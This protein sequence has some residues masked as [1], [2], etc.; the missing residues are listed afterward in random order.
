MIRKYSFALYVALAVMVLPAQAAKAPKGV[1]AKT[2]ADNEAVRLHQKISWLALLGNIGPMCGLLGTVWGMIQAFSSIALDPAQVK[3][4]TMAYSVSKAMI[5]TAAGLML[6]IPA[7][8]AYYYLR[9][10]VI[11]IVAEVEAH[12]SELVELLTREQE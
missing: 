2:A 5:T 6:A 4:M 11:K 8:L 3:G 9:G 12:S 10:R 7:L 1:A